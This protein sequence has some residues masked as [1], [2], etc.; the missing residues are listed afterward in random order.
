MFEVKEINVAYGN[1]QVL[2]DVS[3]KVERGEIVTVIGPNGAGKSTLLRTIIGLLRPMKTHGANS[4]HYNGM[5]IDD[6][7]PHEVVRLGITLVE[8]SRAIFPEMTVLDNLKMGSYLKGARARRG[9]SLAVVYDLFPR[10]EE[11]K[12]QMAR[13]LSGGEQQMLA[14]GRALMCR[15]N[16]LLIDEPTTGLQPSLTARTFDAIKEIKNKGVTVLLVEQNAYL[17]L[18]ISDRAY[19][20][21]NGRIAMEG[22]ASDL[23]GNERVRKVYMAL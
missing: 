13:T 4:I 6:L 14:I 10:L 16:L 19:V 18:E 12:K 11:R 2:W 20:L 23:L 9:E 17:S 5:R 8:E 7:Q 3:L 1:V 21:E 15:P 22:R